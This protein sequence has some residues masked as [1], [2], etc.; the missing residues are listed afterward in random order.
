MSDIDLLLMSSDSPSPDI[1][2]IDVLRRGF[3][4]T[5][6]IR[7]TMLSSGAISL[8]TAAG[9]LS[10]P[11]LVQQVIDRG[12]LGDAGYRPR[13]VLVLSAV[14]LAVVVAV[15]ILTPVAEVAMVR[16]AQNSLYELRRLAFTHIHRLSLA[17]HSRE[18]KGTLLARVT[19]DVETAS[20][21]TEWG[22]LTWSM[23]IW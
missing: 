9:R 13:L 18:Q 4:L 15:S 16:G 8:L 3:R 22:A 21:F 12:L 14:V 11:I 19:S 1:S 17:Q 2:A 23:N 5:P 7:R 20:R 6:G 10:I